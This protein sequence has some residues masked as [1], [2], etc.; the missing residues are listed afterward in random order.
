MMRAVFLTVAMA[1]ALC[2]MQINAMA[3]DEALPPDTSFN[4]TAGRGDVVWIKLTSETSEEFNFGLDTG[5][6]LTVL[7]KSWESKLQP[8][9]SKT[10]VGAR[11]PISGV[12]AAR[13]RY[14]LKRSTSYG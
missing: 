14:I 13:R 10:I 2:L 7:D 6:T 5:A 9:H 1:F 12:F 11:W 8:R 4:P 3:Q